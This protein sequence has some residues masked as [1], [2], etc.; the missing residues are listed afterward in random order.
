MYLR[1]VRNLC[2]VS[3]NGRGEGE[4]PLRGLV[5]QDASQEGSHLTRL[6][7][8]CPPSICGLIVFKLLIL[9]NKH[10]DRNRLI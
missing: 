9:F 10:G 3:V 8:H 1:I 6:P 5:A 4:R 2:V 7:L